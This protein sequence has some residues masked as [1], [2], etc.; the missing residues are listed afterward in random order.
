MIANTSTVLGLDALKL[1]ARDAINGHDVDL[2][3]QVLESI[4]LIDPN[5]PA[6]AY[7]HQWVETT[8]KTNK[9]E[10]NRLETELKGYKN[11]LVKES[12]RVREQ[13]PW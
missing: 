4:R 6:A 9:A 10:L 12:I 13:T 7:N 11:N 1:A 3:K 2:Y 5:N 8:E